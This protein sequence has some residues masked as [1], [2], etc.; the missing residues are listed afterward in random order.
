MRKTSVE[1][2]QIANKIINENPSIGLSEM[3]IGGYRKCE[4]D[5]LKKAN[6]VLEPHIAEVIKCGDVNKPKEPDFVQQIGRTIRVKDLMPKNTDHPQEW[7]DTQQKEL[8]RHYRE[9]F[10]EGMLSGSRKDIEEMVTKCEHW[11]E[12]GEL[13]NTKGFTCR[14]CGKWINKQND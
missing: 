5:Y 8:K 1:L 10:A 13:L 12:L 2:L 14:Y 7:F 11:P 6:Q 9:D 4:I 3:F